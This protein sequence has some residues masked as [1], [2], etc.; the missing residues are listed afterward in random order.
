MKTKKCK[1]CK[2]IKLIPDDFHL[3]RSGKWIKK[4][5]YPEVYR[6]ECKTC[7]RTGGIADSQGSTKIMKKMNIKRPP[8]GTPCYCC[9]S[10]KSV[11]VFD[12]CHTSGTF[13]GWLCHSCNTAIG[14]LGDNIEGLQNAIRY[15]ERSN[16]YFFLQTT[17]KSLPSTPKQS[18][19]TDYFNI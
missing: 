12:H 4:K 8:L 19:I 6:N 10:T 2:Q 16:F 15:L 14:K 5:W 9:K 18:S 11:L 7:R 3:M 1:C 13:R 17:E